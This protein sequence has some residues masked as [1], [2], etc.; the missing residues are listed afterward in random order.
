MLQDGRTGQGRLCGRSAIAHHFNAVSQLSQLGPAK[1]AGGLNR[2]KIYGAPPPLVKLGRD[3]CKSAEKDEHRNRYP[4]HPLKDGR[5]SA[6]LNVYKFED[7]ANAA[8]RS[9][10]ISSVRITAAS[11]VAP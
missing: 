3:Q 11:P 4:I 6:S 10:Q 9:R 8:I 2:F 7:Q 5:Q 1:G